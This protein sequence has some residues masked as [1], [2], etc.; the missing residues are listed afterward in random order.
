MHR[1]RAA[2]DRTC[3]DLKGVD[4]KF[5]NGRALDL[6]QGVLAEL[7]R[8]DGRPSFD[9]VVRAFRR[10]GRRRNGI[11]RRFHVKDLF[12]SVLAL[13]G[14]VREAVFIARDMGVLAP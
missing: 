11:K 6:I 13:Q 2:F 14:I 5:H 12:D 3:S 10:V 7:G 8:P 4:A 1:D 9:E